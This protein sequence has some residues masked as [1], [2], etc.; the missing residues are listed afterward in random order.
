MFK[1]VFS[2]VMNDFIAFKPAIF[3]KIIAS[4]KLAQFFWK[5]ERLRIIM[6]GRVGPIYTQK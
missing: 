6:F 4:F 1:F 2:Y 5:C 3:L